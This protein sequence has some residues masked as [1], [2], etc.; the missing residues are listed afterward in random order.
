MDLYNVTELL[1]YRNYSTKLYEGTVNEAEVDTKDNPFDVGPF[2]EASFFINCSAFTGTNL[3]VKIYKKDPAADK[4]HEVAAF[5]VLTTVGSENKD[6]AA[7]LGD[8]LAVVVTPTGAG[9]KTLTVSANFKI[10]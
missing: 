2:K 1:K 7:N 6:V 8:K 5:T 10:M 3:T 9:D 4:W